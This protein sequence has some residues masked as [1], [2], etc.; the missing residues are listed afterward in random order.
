MANMRN[1]CFI[2]AFHDSAT[3]ENRLTYQHTKLLAGR[4]YNEKEINRHL[5][6]KV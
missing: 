3:L 2:I 5:E 1:F 4:N 6:K